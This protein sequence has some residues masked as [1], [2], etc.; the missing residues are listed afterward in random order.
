M[1]TA[2]N[3]LL[4]ASEFVHRLRPAVT[5]NADSSSFPVA[6]APLQPAAYADASFVIKGRWLCVLENTVCL[7]LYNESA[8]TTIVGVEHEL[9]IESGG[10]CS[11]C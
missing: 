1:K 2:K 10:F 9:L 8:Q 3:R 5:H 6:G 7:E 4:D 11:S